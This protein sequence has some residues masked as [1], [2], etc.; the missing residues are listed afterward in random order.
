MPKYKYKHVC[1]NC[2][3]P[4]VKIT[5]RI[6]SEDIS[7]EFIGEWIHALPPEGD[8]HRYFGCQVYDSSITNFAEPKELTNDTIKS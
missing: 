8:T 5:K 2:G 7:A 4:I 1:A 3:H 6:V